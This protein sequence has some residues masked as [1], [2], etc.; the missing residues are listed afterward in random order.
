MPTA[1]KKLAYYYK[2]GRYY[3]VTADA[4]GG[5]VVETTWADLKALR[6][7]GALTP[8]SFYRITDY[9]CTTTQ[10]N[11]SSAGHLFDIIVLALENNKLCEEAWAAHHTGDTYF[12]NNSLSA[13]K[14]W[15]SLDN[16]TAKY[17]WA[18]SSSGKGVIYRLIDGFNN[19]LPYD[20]KNILFTK[21]GKYTNSYTFGYT[22]D[23]TIKD[24]SLIGTKCSDNVMKPYFSTD[25]AGLNFNV[26]YS[27]NSESNWFNNILGKNCNINTFSYG[28][29]HNVFEELC[30]NNVFGNGCSHNIIKEGLSFSNF[31]AGCS[32]NTF[33]RGC[34]SIIS[35]TS[36]Q[37]NIFEGENL[38]IILG[39]NCSGNTFGYKTSYLYDFGNYCCCNEFGNSCQ[40][41]SFGDSSTTINYCQY[42]VIESGCKNLYINSSDTTASSSNYLQNARVHAGVQGASSSSR[43]TITVPDR[44]LAYSTDYYANG[45]QTVILD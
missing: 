45:S 29:S 37:A 35:G 44:N 31:G 1:T 26:F 13:W 21:T 20:F 32:Y 30:Q 14:V 9:Q 10:S 33:G 6:D 41:I 5:G 36:C 27:S 25:V 40:Y 11:T 34:D 42:N 24:A 28:C 22:E 4:A 3:E 39:N 15:Y 18:D 12:A 16:D 38:E 19:D 23:G 8:G 43:R 7:G 17:G 2:D